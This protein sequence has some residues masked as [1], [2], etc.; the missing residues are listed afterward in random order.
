MK[1]LVGSGGH[2]AVVQEALAQAGILID[3]LCTADET[4]GEKAGSI[5]SGIAL[6][7][8]DDEA[9]DALSASCQI[10]LGIGMTPQSGHRK[11]IYEKYARS[12][13]TLPPLAH[14]SAI[15]ARDCVLSAG[16]QVMAGAVLQSGVRIGESTIVNTGTSLDHHCRVGDHSHIA[17]GVTVCGDTSIGNNVFVGAGVV[18]GP[19]VR[20][21]DGALLGAGAVVLA[22]VAAG[23]RAYGTISRA[24]ND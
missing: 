7:S 4:V 9:V 2:A 16:A 24:A 14:P 12:K 8:S 11:A 22:D 23:E 20:I 13:G 6:F 3:A 19:G 10:F 17:P 15:L 18:I 5:A 21:G 1:L